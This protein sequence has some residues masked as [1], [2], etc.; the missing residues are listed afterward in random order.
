MSTDLILALYPEKSEIT[1]Y[2]KALRNAGTPE[3]DEAAKFLGMRSVITGKD[4]EAYA[5]QCSQVIMDTCKDADCDELEIAGYTFQVI[6]KTNRTYKETEAT[7]AAKSKRAKAEAALKKAKEAE[8][9][10]LLEAGF[11]ECK[12]ASYVKIKD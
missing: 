7:I 5:K 3:P 6:Y 11:E 12:Q 4:G 8:E 2:K 10:A 9:A 1:G